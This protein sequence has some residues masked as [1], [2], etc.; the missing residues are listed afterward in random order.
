[1]TETE[2]RIIEAAIR[3]FV[4]YGPRKTTMA[5][6]AAEAS[7]SRQTLYDTFGGK[8]ELIVTSIRFI[9][10]RNLQVVRGE[11]EGRG[12]LST[13]LDAYFEGTVVKSFELLQTS[14]D[15]EDLISGHNEAGREEIERSHDKHRALVAELLTPYSGALADS[16][17]TLDQLAHFIV[18]V[19]MS[20]KYAAK[21]R[22]DLD[23]LLVTLK[24][25]VSAL[26]GTLVPE[27]AGNRS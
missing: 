20:L 19:A 24:A 26:L 27:P 8:D 16:G 21:C 7:V 10:D 9:T 4:R 13:R 11:L 1:M 12:S 5:D 18:T 23:A 14:G 2:S 25:T 3:T 22:D 15:K 6:I 17:Q